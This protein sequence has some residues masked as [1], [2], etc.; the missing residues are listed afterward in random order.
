M[1]GVDINSDAVGSAKK[2]VAATRELEN[3]I[4]IRHQTNNANIFTGIIKSQEYFD[5]TVCNPPFHTS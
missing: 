3:K 4:E 5:V 2:I 1:V